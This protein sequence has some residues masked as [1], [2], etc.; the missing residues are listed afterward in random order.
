V[1]GK[2]KKGFVRK[3]PFLWGGF[4]F[5]A[6]PPHAFF[7]CFLS[8]SVA[9]RRESWY[10]ILLRGGSEQG[11]IPREALIS[12]YWSDFFVGAKGTELY[13]RHGNP[14]CGGVCRQVYQYILFHPA[15]E[16]SRRRGHGIFLYGV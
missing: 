4:L 8:A 12:R 2:K 3:A 13:Q 1:G 7:F 9:K 10:T 15:G 16:F 6:L 14:D 11:K 5:S